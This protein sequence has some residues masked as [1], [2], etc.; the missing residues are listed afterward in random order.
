MLSINFVVSAPQ[1]VQLS[2]M[3]HETL[4]QQFPKS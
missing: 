3:K 2:N 1:T 4:E